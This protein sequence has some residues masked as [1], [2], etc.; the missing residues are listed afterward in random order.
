MMCP[1]A[2]HRIA[3]SPRSKHNKDKRVANESVRRI[4]A[5]QKEQLLARTA[6]EQPL[7]KPHLAEV[8]REV[9]R[10]TAK[11]FSRTVHCSASPQ[12]ALRSRCAV[13]AGSFHPHFLR[14]ALKVS[15]VQQTPR[16][17]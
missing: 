8:R 12:L 15:C 4:F 14:E 2:S 11:W 9:L 16:A 13:R 10:G 7:V 6:Q 1:P 17:I 3:G 5:G